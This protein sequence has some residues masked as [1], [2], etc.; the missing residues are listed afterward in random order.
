MPVRLQEIWAT[1]ERLGQRF[2][3]RGNEFLDELGLFLEIPPSRWEYFCTPLN[4]VTFG[5][6]GGDG[7]HY[8]LLQLEGVPEHEQP[9]IM[10]VPMSD[11]HNVV[12]AENLEEFLSLGYHVGWFS[13]EQIVYQS[14][15]VVAAY[16]AAED[17]D[18]SPDQKQRLIAFRE[19]L[20][21]NHQRISSQRLADLERRFKSLVIAASE[22]EEFGPPPN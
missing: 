9:V 3:V 1:A 7:V 11:Q 21:L 20:A 14:E 19:E 13:L 8:G 15:E 16:H 2:G 12:V 17:P 5:S 4:S 22:P 10:T 6:T 18:E